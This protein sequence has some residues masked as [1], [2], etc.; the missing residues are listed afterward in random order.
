[1][2]D[3]VSE[4]GVSTGNPSRYV[5]YFDRQNTKISETFFNPILFDNRYVAY[6]EEN[7]LY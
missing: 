4:I 3:D 7:K 6:M 1:M 2:T 5:F